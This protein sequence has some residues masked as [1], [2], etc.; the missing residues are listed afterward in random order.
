MLPFLQNITAATLSG[1]LFHKHLQLRNLQILI[2]RQIL[3]MNF[4]INWEISISFV[5][6]ATITKEKALWKRP[7][8]LGHKN[9]LCYSFRISGSASI[10]SIWLTVEM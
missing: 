3:T 6:M 1:G 7:H 8:R 9:T 4:H 5:Q 10:F 2:F